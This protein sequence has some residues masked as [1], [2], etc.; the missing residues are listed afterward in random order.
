MFSWKPFKILEQQFLFN[1][2]GRLF[3]SLQT[4]PIVSTPSCLP[5]L[6]VGTNVNYININIIYIIY[7]NIYYI[8]YIYKFYLKM[9]NV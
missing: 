8:I 7:I 6:C 1:T 3:V 2:F 4:I 9:Y 5:Y